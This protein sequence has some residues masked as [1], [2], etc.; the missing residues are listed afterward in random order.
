MEH[1]IYNPQAALLKRQKETK[2][3]EIEEDQKMKKL[4]CLYLH[5]ID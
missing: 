5:I 4:I 2:L 1:G 3:R